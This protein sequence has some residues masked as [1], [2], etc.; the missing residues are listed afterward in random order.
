MLKNCF[1]WLTLVF[2]Q[3]NPLLRIETKHICQSTKRI[4]GLA[5]GANSIQRGLR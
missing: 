4:A 5:F 3:I 1:S 2:G